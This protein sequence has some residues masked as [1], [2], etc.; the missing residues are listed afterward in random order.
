MVIEMQAM[1][2]EDIQNQNMKIEVA[3]RE[4]ELKN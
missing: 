2:F 4:R 1:E 3:C